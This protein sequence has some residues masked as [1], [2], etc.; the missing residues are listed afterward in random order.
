MICNSMRRWRARTV[1]A[2]A[3]L[4]A[5]ILA[6]PNS[7]CATHGPELSG[8]TCCNFHYRKTRVPDID[9]RN[10]LGYRRSASGYWIGDANWSSEPWIPAGT[11]IR[12]KSYSKYSVKVDV[13]VVYTQEMHLGLDFGRDQDINDWVRKMIVLEDPKPKIW[14][15]PEPVRRAVA[16]G[17][18]AIGMTREQVIVSLG[19]PPAHETPSLDV[20]R[21]KYWYGR[22]DT[23][24]VVWD[25]EG[26]V[27]DVI[28]DRQVRS[29]VMP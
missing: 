19:Y 21:W 8:Y 1:V 6:G 4:L 15:W 9:S 16:T 17:K 13:D 2:A 22:F 5:A 29:A 25:D 20:D 11:P 3:P 27:G 18:V 12:T 14:N 26:R 23:F 7:G 24:L 28:A 10:S